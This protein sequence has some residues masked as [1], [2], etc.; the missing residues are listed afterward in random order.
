MT[1]GASVFLVF[2]LTLLFRILP[3]SKPT[4]S[5]APSRREP[6]FANVLLN[7]YYT[8]NHQ[9]ENLLGGLLFS[10]LNLC[11]KSFFSHYPP[12]FVDIRK[13]IKIFIIVVIK[14]TL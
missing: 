7:L 1:E 14:S 11:G 5:T 2:G 9:G 3:Q 8:T 12:H 10:K 4:V 13:G 6:Y